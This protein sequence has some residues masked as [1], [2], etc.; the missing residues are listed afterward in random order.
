MKGSSVSDGRHG[1]RSVPGS[2]YQAGNTQPGVSAQ[3]GDA[4]PTRGTWELSTPV[5]EARFLDWVRRS[6]GDCL[7]DTRA[8]GGQEARKS[9]GVP[10]E[11][12]SIGQSA[13][14]ARPRPCCRRTP[15][16]PR[17]RRRRLVSSCATMALRSPVL[18]RS[19]KTSPSKGRR[20]APR[21]DPAVGSTYKVGV[22]GR[23]PRYEPVPANRL[24]PAGQ[25]RWDDF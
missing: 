23:S 21:S 11:E 10:R 9:V 15:P 4:R 6:R 17:G 5:S 1:T 13:R 3:V 24:E 18:G 20:I 14:R 7:R 16:I 22:I 19:E 25:R 8:A 12:F 2:R